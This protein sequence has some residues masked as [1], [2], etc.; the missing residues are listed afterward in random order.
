LCYKAADI[1][2]LL[3]AARHR[4][5]PVSGITMKKKRLEKQRRVPVYNK[6]NENG[7]RRLWGRKIYA[8]N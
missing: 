7:H 8:D 5:M 2:D 6:E 3:P 4:K 1:K